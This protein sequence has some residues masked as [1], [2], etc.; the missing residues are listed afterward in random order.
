MTLIMTG[1][2]L[3]KVHVRSW[4]GNTYFVSRELAQ[5]SSIRLNCKSKCLCEMSDLN[6]MG[7]M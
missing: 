7:Y 5:D 3:I 6:N 1:L 4:G 2:L